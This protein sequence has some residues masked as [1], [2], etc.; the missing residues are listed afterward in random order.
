M[1]LE[2]PCKQLGIIVRATRA[3]GVKEIE[4]PFPCQFSLALWDILVC[5]QVCNVALVDILLLLIECLPQLINFTY[6]LRFLGL[7]QLK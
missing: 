5:R 3:E 2:E 1:E 6:L 7:R 4:S